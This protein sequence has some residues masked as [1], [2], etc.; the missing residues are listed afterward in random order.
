[1]CACVCLGLGLGVCV[2]H[3]VFS[4]VSGCFCSLCGCRTKASTDRQVVWKTDLPQE[5]SQLWNLA[6]GQGVGWAERE[7]KQG[8]R[9]PLL[10]AGADAVG[11]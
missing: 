10:Q 5:S 7:L 11:S 4:S 1:M 8:L 3:T 6:A 9:A 2:S